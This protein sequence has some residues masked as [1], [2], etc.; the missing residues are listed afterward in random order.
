MAR[1]RANDLAYATATISPANWA[2]QDDYGL[3][4]LY[5]DG[6]DYYSDYDSEDYY[7]E[8]DDYYDEEDD[9][10]DYGTGL[11]SLRQSTP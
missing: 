1:N 6:D 7:D 11:A 10:L 5:D 9:D 3:E 8:E 2:D 4:N